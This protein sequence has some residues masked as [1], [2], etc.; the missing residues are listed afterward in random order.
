MTKRGKV[1]SAILVMSVLLI[2]MI[3]FVS[4]Q[5]TFI[6]NIKSIAYSI[7]NVL[8]SAFIFLLNIDTAKLTAQDVLVNILFFILIFGISWFILNK[9]EF[10]EGNTLFLGGITFIISILAVRGFSGLGLVNTILLPYTALGVALAAGIPFV[11]WFII[12]NIGF[13]EQ[14]RIIRQVGWIFFAVI[15]VGLWIWRYKELAGFSWIYPVTAVLAVIMTIIDGTIS[16][17]F[18]KF[19]AEKL[20]DIN[21]KAVIAELSEKIQDTKTMLTSGAID[22]DTASTLIKNYQ[23]KIKFFSKKYYK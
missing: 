4:A 18:A 2:F 1:F 22:D 3:N 19:Q 8:N 7:G 15:F 12:F 17:L 23:N 14:P 6:E 20:K 16:G 10:L 5:D 13:K 21:K 9:I 11:M